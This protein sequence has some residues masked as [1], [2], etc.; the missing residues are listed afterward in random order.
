MEESQKAEAFFKEHKLK[1]LSFQKY[2]MMHTISGAELNDLK[3][4]F[5]KAL[6]PKPAAASK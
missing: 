5:V 3:R 2:D 4:W 6:E 1:H